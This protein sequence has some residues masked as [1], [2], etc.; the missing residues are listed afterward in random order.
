M[1]IKTLFTALIYLTICIAPAHAKKP[2]RMDI[3][4]NKFKV[5]PVQEVT[6]ESVEI[7][8]KE[9]DKDSAD[10]TEETK[11]ETEKADTVEPAK[12]AEI[13]SAEIKASDIKIEKE[14]GSDSDS[15]AEN[16]NSDES[17][18][19]T[20]PS[21]YD[22]PDYNKNDIIS[23]G[24]T[25]P[26]TVGEED[27]LLDIARA[28]GLGFIEMRLANPGIDPWTP[29]PNSKVTLPLQNLLPRSAQKGIII[30][31]A[32]MRL[33]YFKDSKTAP[34][35]YPIGIGRAGLETPLGETQIIRKKANPSWRPTQRMRDEKPDL[36]A[37]VLAGNSNPLG[38]HALYLGWPTFLIHGTNKPW[39]IGRRVSSG[40]IR[41]YPENI[42]TLFEQVPTSTPVNIVNQPIKIGWVKDKLYLEVHPSTK[43]SANIE[44]KGHEAKPNQELPEAFRQLV[45]DNAKD[46][47]DLINWKL[48]KQTYLSQNGYPVVIADLD[49][50]PKPQKKRTTPAFNS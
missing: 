48:V 45:T 4:A 1:F 39:G 11:A 44:L 21:P 33:Y 43:D 22:L 6:A 37:V 47:A 46:K 27:T 16:E 34:R 7:E 25:E 9:I 5:K 40:C 36:P 14:D 38:T 29:E 3:T 17:D 8:A 32:E 10:G 35:S 50:K 28:F 18:A 30:N 26:Y 13:T 23:M 41:M 2:E 42:L 12:S 24:V 31:L 19:E 15:N 20:L 49:K